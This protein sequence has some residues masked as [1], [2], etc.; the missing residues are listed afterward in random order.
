MCVCLGR[1]SYALLDEV[2]VPGEVE[3]LTSLVQDVG[4]IR[5]GCDF[6]GCAAQVGG[7][8][9]DMRSHLVDRCREKQKSELEGS[10]RGPK[11]RW[12]WGSRW[13]LC[14]PG[15]QAP[16]SDAMAGWTCCLSE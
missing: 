15:S 1:L 12:I 5:G 7:Y 6:D 10:W 8:D 9:D 11:S 13:S 3:L 14:L 4:E 16:T 2:L